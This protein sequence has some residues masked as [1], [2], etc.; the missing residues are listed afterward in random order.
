MK[1]PVRI[2]LF[3]ALS[4]A[5][6]GPANTVQAAMPWQRNAV[7]DDT[8]RSAVTDP[9]ARSF[10]ERI[11]WQPIWSPQRADALVAAIGEASR[12]GMDGQRFLRLV[13]EAG[14]PAARE[15]A[16]TQAALSYGHG[17][18]FGMVDPANLHDHYTLER[19]T[20]DLVG[21]LATAAKSGDIGGWLESLAPSDP[22]YRALSDAY[23]Q[24]T[25]KGGGIGPAKPVPAG[26]LLKP[27]DRDPRMVLIARALQTAGYDVSIN[28]EKSSLY[29]PE[30]E[31]AVRAFQADRG[32]GVDGVIGAGTIAALN[33]KPGVHARQLALNL[34]RRRWL[35]RNP[36]ERRIDVNTA[37]TFLTY[38]R[39]GQPA[40]TTRVVTGKS[41][42][43][44]P[45][46]GSLMTRLVVNPP[47]Y[48]P[49]SIAKKEV[50]PK[51]AAYLRREDM[52]VENGRVI[53]RPGPKAALGQVKFDLDNPYAIYLHDTPS[54]AL[55]E[56]NERH[57]SHGCVR[58]QNALEFA[59]MLAEEDGNGALFDEKLASG[60]T[61]V[62]NFERD[63]PVRLLYH[64]AWLGED[65]R[66]AYAPD[67]YGW[68]DKLAQALG[69][70]GSG[71]AGV[72]ST[73]ADLGP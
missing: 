34:E 12:H 49:D 52:Y 18:A 26:K 38:W 20:A 71:E 25:G 10:Y 58:V 51:G 40:Y 1:S 69:M 17:L 6:A 43:A 50:F 67:A 66:I 29:T 41:D 28:A 27:G 14:S 21:G 68:D 55:F 8:L 65:D 7:S 9:L 30:I 45:A 47:W 24:A 2:A 64:T 5:A 63:I 61:G 4:L 11:G 13:D 32:L 53:Q 31:A 60:K 42:T 44:T 3:C 36:A 72:Q 33:A 39:G 23:V 57:A 16:L 19:P 35:A 73:A 56:R 37:G 22:E 54:K 48:V 62:V 15:A 59:R 70:G 46:L